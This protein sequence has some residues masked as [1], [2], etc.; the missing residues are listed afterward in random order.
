MKEVEEHLPLASILS[1]SKENSS[2][3][4]SSEEAEGGAFVI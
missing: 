4:Y 1:G 2:E 3:S